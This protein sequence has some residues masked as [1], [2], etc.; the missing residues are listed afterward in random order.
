MR[1]LFAAA[2]SLALLASTAANAQVFALR[3]K[4]ESILP[5]AT[6]EEVEA[7]LGTPGATS[8]RGNVIAWQYCQNGLNLHTYGFVWF[9][10]NAAYSTDVIRTERRTWLC[11]R[12]FRE[13]DWSPIPQALL[14]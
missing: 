6:M 11:Q 7:I 5:G 14:F 2:L 1:I 8:F 4:I 10:N 12:D 3:G 9:F 13:F